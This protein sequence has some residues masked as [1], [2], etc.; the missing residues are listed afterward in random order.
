MKQQLSV[1]S[2]QLLVNPVRKLGQ[3]FLSNG[4]KK[5]LISHFLFLILFITGYWIL[6]TAASAATADNLAERIQNKYAVIQDIQGIFYQTSYLKDLESVEQYEGEFFI[7]KPSFI[8]WRY[9]KPRDEEVI[10]RGADAWIY[11]KSE[12]Q[13]FKTAFSKYTY[14]QAPIALLSSFE[15]LKTDFDIKMI[16]EDTLELKPKHQKG[17]IK[18]ILLEVSSGDFPTKTFSIFDIHGNKVDIAVRNVRINSGLKDSFFFFKLPPGVE[19][20]DFN[21]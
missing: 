19:V 18:K 8:R 10:V 3:A 1:A 12:K 21:P 17:F 16:K 5:I 2:C 14:N 20:F 11:K 7:K 4:I 13:V 6:A 9:S 15:T